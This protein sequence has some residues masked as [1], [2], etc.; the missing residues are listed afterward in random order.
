MSKRWKSHVSPAV[1]TPI[2]TGPHVNGHTAA[3]QNSNSHPP[4]LTSTLRVLRAI[5]SSHVNVRA[6]ALSPCKEPEPGDHPPPPTPPQSFSV[7]YL[8]SSPSNSPP[9]HAFFQLVD[10]LHPPKSSAAFDSHNVS[11][12]VAIALVRD[13]ALTPPMLPPPT[14]AS[15]PLHRRPSTDLHFQFGTLFALHF[16][17]LL[18][19]VGSTRKRFVC[20]SRLQA[21]RPFSFVNT[22][23]FVQSSTVNLDQGCIAFRRRTD[24]SMENLPGEYW[25]AVYGRTI[26]TFGPLVVVAFARDSTISRFIPSRAQFVAGSTDTVFVQYVKEANNLA[27]NGDRSNVRFDRSSRLALKAQET[28]VAP[29]TVI[30][31][32]IGLKEVMDEHS[33]G[34]P[35]IKLRDLGAYP[36]LGSRLHRLQGDPHEQQR[37][38]ARHRPI[39]EPFPNVS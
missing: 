27:N 5:C 35:D 18:H 10:S 6:F 26:S 34:R 13:G 23:I 24:Y 38:R 28:N 15:L 7:Y 3:R 33:S 30:G 22:P 9:L 11:I 37:R 1:R 16:F 8:Q 31:E 32:V 2:L 14:G 17:A 21:A 20:V 39:Y 29:V 12:S 36:E 4:S 25:A 19:F